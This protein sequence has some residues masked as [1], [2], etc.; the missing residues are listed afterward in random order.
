MLFLSQWQNF[1]NIRSPQILITPKEQGAKEMREEVM[2]SGGSHNIDTNGSD[3]SE[4]VDI[5]FFWKTL[6]WR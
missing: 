4:L 2:S 1:F 5:E 6:S 3:L